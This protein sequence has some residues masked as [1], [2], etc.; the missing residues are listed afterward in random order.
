MRLAGG[1]S[2][3]GAPVRPQGAWEPAAGCQPLQNRRIKHRMQG[4]LVHIVVPGG[5]WRD[6]QAA[7]RL[8]ELQL[9]SAR[10]CA[11]P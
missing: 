1:C 8:W 10:A 4:T 2:D 7:W 11:V 9:A 6:G 3:A 5:M